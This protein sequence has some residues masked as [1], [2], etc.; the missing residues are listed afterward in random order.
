MRMS[1][2][3]LQGVRADAAVDPVRETVLP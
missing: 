2:A 3:A 1:V